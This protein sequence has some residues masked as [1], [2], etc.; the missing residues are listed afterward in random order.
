MLSKIVQ[1]WKGFT[2]REIN[3]RR[4]KRGSLWQDEYWDR[5]IRSEAHL[6]KVKDYIRNNPSLAKLRKGQYVYWES[7]A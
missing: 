5:L 2:A 3:K 1:S 4:G 7:D 6:I